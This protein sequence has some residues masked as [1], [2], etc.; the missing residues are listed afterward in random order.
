MNVAVAVPAAL[1]SALCFGVASVVQQQAAREA[2]AQESLRLRLLLDLARRPKWLLGMG[3]VISSYALLGLAL[4]FGPLVLVQPLAATDLVFALPLL[5]WRRRMPLTRNRFTRLAD[6]H[7]DTAYPMSCADGHSDRR[8]Q[9]G[10]SVGL[11]AETR[12]RPSAGG[13]GVRQSLLSQRQL[14]QT[15]RHPFV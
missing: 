8:A 7:N 15:L 4:T 12:S 13:S 10:E 1:L 2:R 6:Q 3:L 5:A 11:P 9:T 14:S